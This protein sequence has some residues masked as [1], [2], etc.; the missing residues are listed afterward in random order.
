MKYNRSNSPK[1]QIR[2][3]KAINYD[4][5][6]SIDRL[7]VKRSNYNAMFEF[8]MIRKLLFCSVKQIFISFNPLIRTIKFHIFNS[9]KGIII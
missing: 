4:A 3:G 5:F 1:S 2:K 6:S 9:R 8:V 7:I